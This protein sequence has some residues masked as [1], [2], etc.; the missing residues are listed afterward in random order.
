[1]GNAITKENTSGIKKVQTYQIFIA[2]KKPGTS[3]KTVGRES[4]KKK[5]RAIRMKITRRNAIIEKRTITK[6]RIATRRRR[7]EKNMQITSLK[8]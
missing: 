7:R 8:L 5:Q 6:K 4:G 1:M 2:A 3:R